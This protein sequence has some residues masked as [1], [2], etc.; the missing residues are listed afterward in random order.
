MYMKKKWKKNLKFKLTHKNTSW[1]ISPSHVTI[2]ILLFLLS[3]VGFYFHLL[4]LFW[5]NVWTIGFE[6][7]TRSLKLLNCTIGPYS[8]LFGRGQVIELL[9]L[10]FFTCKTGVIIT[11]TYLTGVLWGSTSTCL[12]CALKSESLI[13]VLKEF[14]QQDSSFFFFFF[15]FCLCGGREPVTLSVIKPLDTQ[16]LSNRS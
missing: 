12:W 9:C 11:L 14:L 10:C 15:F 13:E 1:Y 8:S 6:H 4:S 5:K 2:Q 3:S 7:R 16:I